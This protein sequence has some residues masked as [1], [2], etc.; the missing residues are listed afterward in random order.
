MIQIHDVKQGSEAWHQ[1]H[2]GLWTGTTALRLLQGKPLPVW[3]TFGGN[4][5]TRRGKLLE[6]VA[7]REFEMQSDGGVLTVGFVTNSRYPNAGFSPDG[8]FGDTLLE[9]KCLNG[10]RHEKL[11]AGK[12]P[13]EY[14][15]Q[16]LFGLVVCEL[17]RGKLLAF[18]PEYEQQLTVIDII[19]TQNIIDNIQRKLLT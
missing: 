13:L 5:W 7:I 12:I 4:K 8:I 19:P 15:V 11:M 1:L 14:Q 10:E 17:P 2:D 9:V 18:N 6:H 16:V 3:S